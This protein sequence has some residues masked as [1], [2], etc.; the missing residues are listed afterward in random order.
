MARIIYAWEL[1]GDYGHIGSFMPL[2]LELR[3]QGHEVIFVLRD[4]SNAETVVSKYKFSILQ[5][6]IWTAEIKGLPDPPLNY[7]EIIL[8]YGFISKPALSALN[9]AWIGL[10]ALIKPDFIIADHSPVALFSARAVG[11]P[12]AVY[13]T[14]FCSPPHISPMPNMRPWAKVS[15]KRLEESDK[16]VLAIANSLLLDMQSKAPPLQAIADLFKV[17]VDFLCTFPEMDHYPQRKNSSYWGPVFNIQHGKAMAWAVADVSITDVSVPDVSIPEV[18]VPDVSLNE[19]I[20]KQPSKKVKPTKPANLAQARKRIFVYI[21]P[22]YKNYEKILAC[23]KAMS[24][25]AKLADV[26]I[27]SP[28]ISKKI[29]QDY[30]NDY[31][32][33]A[34][35]PIQLASI[36]PSCDLAICHAGHGTMAACLMAGVPLLLLPM[37]LEQFLASQR[38]QQLG[39]AKIVHL[40][41]K[42][43]IDYNALITDLLSNASYKQKAQ[44][45]A[46]H[47]SKF[48]QANQFKAMAN[49]IKQ[50]LKK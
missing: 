13:G 23:L 37:Q 1:G 22:S 14:G 16:H 50:I 28:G 33:F 21:K 18:S 4:L 43:Q 8:R 35:E 34:T 42:E 45:F 24:L 48:D 5:A 10:F 20:A 25:D 6:P 17:D 26:I 49:K 36:L 44:N 15:Q 2:A 7:T 47:Y 27:F 40:E 38:L 12:R 46:A 29:I 39:A 32:R 3:E 11:L 30:E 31:L 41:A 9:R 19:K